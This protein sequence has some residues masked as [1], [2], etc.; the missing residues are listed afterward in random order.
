MAS[1]SNSSCHTRVYPSTAGAESTTTRQDA[2]AL[3]PA[4]EAVT[5]A[6]PS[7][8]AFTFPSAETDATSGADELHPTAFASD[9][10]AVSCA[11]S[12]A[13]RTSCSSEML[14][15][16][17]FSP[18]KTEHAQNTKRAT[19]L[20][21]SENNNFPHRFAT[22]IGSSVCLLFSFTLSRAPGSFA[23][24]PHKPSF[25]SNRAHSV[26]KRASSVVLPFR[27]RLQYRLCKK[28]FFHTKKRKP[29]AHDEKRGAG[30]FCSA[31]H[32]KTVPKTE[33]SA[34]KDGA[35]PFPS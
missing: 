10:T 27:T 25:V 17:C 21:A 13:A 24:I 29:S 32:G 3:P 34:P 31:T 26:K 7:D 9:A 11:S 2:C 16:T 18:S 33:K 20:T 12:P 8:I 1:P 5:T 15:K 19:T 30:D 14:I 35:L 28:D 4:D 22:D 6:S 23:I